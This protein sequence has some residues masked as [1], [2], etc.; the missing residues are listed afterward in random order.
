M[1]FLL[2]L[3]TALYRFEI[4][5]V[6]RVF[7]VATK[8]I[9]GGSWL[10]LNYAQEP[11]CLMSVEGSSPACFCGRSRC[12]G[13]IGFTAQQN[14]WKVGLFAQHI[15]AERRK[16]AKKDARL[17]AVVFANA[18]RRVAQPERHGRSDDAP[19]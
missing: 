5:G 11:I 3:M 8:D 16:A 14:A 1:P 19:R 7:L 10:T 12:T 13:F 9:P 4:D 2:N 6:Q 15:E 17:D 18:Q